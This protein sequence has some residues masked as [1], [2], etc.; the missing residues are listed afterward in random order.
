MLWYQTLKHKRQW[1]YRLDGYV[2][3][4]VAI[5]A[6]IKEGKGVSESDF[7]LLAVESGSFILRGIFSPIRIH[8]DI[9]VKGVRWVIRI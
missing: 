9:A 8:V 3:G 1:E 7:E 4:R 5:F 2:L 6:I